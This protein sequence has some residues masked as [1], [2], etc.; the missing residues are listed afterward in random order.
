[1]S[2]W[3]LENIPAVFIIQYFCYLCQETFFARQLLNDRKLSNY[4]SEKV[5]TGKRGAFP[6]RV[7]VVD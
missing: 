1:P 6:Q 7:G 2:G 4:G 3:I 5:Y